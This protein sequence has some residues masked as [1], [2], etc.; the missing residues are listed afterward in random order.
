MVF[1]S[2]RD[3]FWLENKKCLYFISFFTLQRFWRRVTIFC[4]IDRT[5]TNFW[6]SYD[7]GIYLHNITPRCQWVWWIFILHFHFHSFIFFLIW[8]LNTFRLCWSR[9]I[10]FKLF[11]PPGTHS[12]CGRCKCQT[13]KVFA[14][15]KQLWNWTS[16]WWGARTISGETMSWTLKLFK[17]D[18]IFY[19]SWHKLVW[20]IK[21]KSSS[22]YLC[23]RD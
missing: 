12:K 16:I 11:F 5:K 21:T 1:S 7:I 6:L 2:K 13:R 22:Y 18:F 3:T 17:A 14:W 19:K 10:Q 15:Q 20:E 9:M 4:Y 23:Q 8:R